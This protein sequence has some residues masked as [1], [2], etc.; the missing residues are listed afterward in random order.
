MSWIFL[1]IKDSFFIVSFI[2]MPCAFKAFKSQSISYKIRPIK[3]RI[4][5]QDIYAHGLC[6]VLFCFLVG[7]CCLVLPISHY[8]PSTTKLLWGWYIGFTM[9]VRPSILVEAWWHIH[10]LVNWVVLGTK[11]L[12][13]PMLTYVDCSQR[14][15]FQS[16]FILKFK[17]NSLGPS[18]AIWRWRSWSTLVQVMACCLTA[19][20]H[21]LNQCWLIISKVL[22]H[23]SEDI[24]MR[25]FEDTNQ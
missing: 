13:E 12:F 7:W 11:P 19:P 21:Y 5:F 14:Y 16:N 20:S 6:F 15:I 25:R 17:F 22:W 24:I 4:T 3:E 2:L 1:E 9:Y 23:S 8:T 10:A 18:D